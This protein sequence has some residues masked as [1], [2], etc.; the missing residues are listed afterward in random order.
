MFYPFGNQSRQYCILVR[1]CN[2]EIKFMDDKIRIVHRETA[3]GLSDDSKV[4][5]AD[6]KN[7][8]WV[9]EYLDEDRKA[10]DEGLLGLGTSIEN[11]EGIIGVETDYLIDTDKYYLALTY[12]KYDNIGDAIEYEDHPV[13]AYAVVI[14]EK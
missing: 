1:N 11:V 7:G 5:H 10:L 6:Y 14:C 2:K 12:A 8:K 3:I 13:F 4:R 9:F